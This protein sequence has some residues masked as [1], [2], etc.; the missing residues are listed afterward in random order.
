M[1]TSPYLCVSTF[2]EVRNCGGLGL[3]KRQ[4][5]VVLYLFIYFQHCL[6]GVASSWMKLFSVLQKY[7]AYNQA[8]IHENSS[9][10]IT[11]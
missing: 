10:A 5:I 4:D 8:V 2:S 11:H 6:N 1:V 3:Q 7:T 9:R